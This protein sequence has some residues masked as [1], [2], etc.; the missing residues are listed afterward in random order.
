[1]Y[2]F[3]VSEAPDETGSVTPDDSKQLKVRGPQVK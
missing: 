3:Q 1:M 2:Y